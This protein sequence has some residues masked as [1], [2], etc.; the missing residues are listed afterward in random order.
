MSS[1]YS[2][3]FCSLLMSREKTL[4]LLTNHRTCY[5][6]INFFLQIL[7]NAAE[8]GSLVEAWQC[9]KIPWDHSNAFAQKVLASMAKKANVMA[10]VTH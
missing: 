3:P 10:S 4:C 9:V 6:K 7:M 2:G 5:F 1:T 8:R